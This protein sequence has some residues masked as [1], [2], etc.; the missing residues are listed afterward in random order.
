[1]A[2][3]HEMTGDIWF[4]SFLWWLHVVITY[5]MCCVSSRLHS[6]PRR[7][8]RSEYSNWQTDCGAHTHRPG[9]CVWTRPHS[10]DSGNCSVSTDTGHRRRNGCSRRWRNLQT[11]CCCQMFLAKIMHMPKFLLAVY[12][13]SKLTNNLLYWYSS[14]ISTDFQKLQWLCCFFVPYT[15]ISGITANWAAK[16]S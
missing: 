6:R 16:F 11:V 7:Q 9:G 13:V 2:W 3:R 5:L 14:C 8:A 12:A 1:M 10:T 4:H 15:N